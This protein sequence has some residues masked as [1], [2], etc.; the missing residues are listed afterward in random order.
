MHRVRGSC[1]L[2][3]QGLFV[4]DIV[5]RFAE[6]LLYELFSRGRLSAHGR[7]D[8]TRKQRAGPIDISLDVWRR[9]GQDPARIAGVT[10]QVTSPASPRSD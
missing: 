4:N 3:F 5:V 8:Q 9:Y 7:G 10:R 2:A 1:R 6:Q